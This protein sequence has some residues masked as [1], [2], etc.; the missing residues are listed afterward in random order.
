[1]GVSGDRLA[2]RGDS[3]G[4]AALSGINYRTPL[5]PFSFRPISRALGYVPG[6]R[7]QLVMLVAPCTS[8]GAP[9]ATTGALALGAGF[10]EQYRELSEPSRQRRRA[11][12]REHIPL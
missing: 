5:S 6:Y 8:L 9:L 7:Q 3:H 11:A 2:T 4:S 1:M 12:K 10:L